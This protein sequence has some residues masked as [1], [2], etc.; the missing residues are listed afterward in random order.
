MN[1]AI[2]IIGGLIG[3]LQAMIAIHS[4]RLAVKNKHLLHFLIA[5][6][7]SSIAIGSIILSF[8]AFSL[9]GVPALL[10]VMFL[11]VNIVLFSAQLFFH[12]MM[13]RRRAIK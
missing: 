2:W 1:Q 8:Q 3:L 4:I 12:S 10:P 9:G 7:V 13:Q 5:L 6:S 11:G